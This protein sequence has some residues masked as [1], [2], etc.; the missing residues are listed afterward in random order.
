MK[1]GKENKDKSD[2]SYY[3]YGVP[4]S[5]TVSNSLYTFVNLILVT[6]IIVLSPLM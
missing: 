1:K 5:G 3:V 2:N 6:M 4:V